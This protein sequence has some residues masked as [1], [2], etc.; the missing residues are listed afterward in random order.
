MYRIL[1]VGTGSIG[2][3]HVRCMQAT[4]RVEV[5]ICEINDSVRDQVAAR[6]GVAKD[7]ASLDQALRDP[8]DAVVIASPAHT[9]IPI[10]LQ[11]ADV[12]VSMLIEKPLSVNLDGVDELV[13]YVRK[14]NLLVA[15]AYVY[16]AH[17]SLQKMKSMIDSGRFGNPL[18]VAVV[19]GQDFSAFRPAYRDTYFNDRKTGGGAIQDA[20]THYINAVEWLV[21]P[22][23]RVA[24]DAAH[25]VLSDVTVEDTVNMLARH[26]T[27][28]ACYSLNMYQAPSELTM[29]VV[30]EGGTLRFELHKKRFRW[31]VA[32]DNP[33]G[34]SE[35]HEIPADA[36]DL[37]QWFTSQEHAFLDALGGIAPPLCTLAEAT[38]TLRVNLAALASADQE[39]AWCQV[40]VLEA[41]GNP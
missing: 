32:P 21:G 36:S 33:D 6:Y 24:V 16:R 35:W 39:G 27:V 38:Q 22:V 15:V 29:T 8:W 5:S 2:E 1:I 40:A 11:V 7:Y 23:E 30:C 31:K 18:Q 25:K 26:G 41:M 9:H 4:G 14:H 19:S 37:D 34:L 3:R 20:L 13:D 12:G 28:M 10:A 17:P